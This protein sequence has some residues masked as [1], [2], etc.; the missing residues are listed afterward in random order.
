MRNVVGVRSSPAYAAV[1]AGLAAVLLVSAAGHPLTPARA[2]ACTDTDPI[3]LLYCQLGGSASVLGTPLGAPYTVGAG[4]GQDY[5]AGSIVWSSPT[6]AHEV[7]GVIAARYRQLRG[8]TGLMGFPTSDQRTAA[9]GVGTY[10]HFQGGSIF[11]SP[12][13][14][15][16]EVRGLLRDR[17]AALGW[18]RGLLGY[19]VGGTRAA[20]KDGAG[21]S[22]D[23]Q[24]GSI[25]W[26][27][28][29]GAWEVRGLLRD[30][31]RA[32]GSESG[33]LGYPTSGTRTAADTV[34]RYNHFQGGSIFWSPSTGAWEVRGVLRDRWAALGWER[35]VLGYPVTGSWATADTVGRYNRFQ[36]GS[37]FY[38]PSTGAHAVSGVI[39][40]RWAASGAERGPLGYPIT[41]EY[42]VNGGRQSDFQR[43]FLRLTSATGS[44]RQ[45]ILAPY[46]RAGT[47]VTR[48]RFSREF[49]GAAPPITPATVDAMAAAGVHTIYI[50]A[51]ADD[52]RFPGLLSP[53]LLAA[54]LTR[55]HARGLQVV[56][57]YLPHL[58]DVNADMR[59]LQAMIDFRASGQAFDAIGVDIEDLSVTD[60]DTRNARLVDLSAR[61]F[62]AAPN[63]T[64]S[65]I[66]LPPVVTDVLNTAYWPRFPWRQLAGYYQVWMPMAYWS[67]RT[68]LP[69]SD[70][71][72][73]TTENI[74][75]VRQN[76]GESCAA[77]SVIGGYGTAVSSAA[78]SAMATGARER[79]AIG[80]SIFDW[81]T[82]PSASWA[83]VRGYN[84]RGC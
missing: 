56:A 9:D 21:R 33:V 78:Y 77:V 14:G 15:A 64:L 22:N 70:A 83:A 40:A 74:N 66:V 42:A 63:V 16:W 51:A 25:Y 27:A 29:T 67:N 17:W 1:V 82:T 50:Q 37:I 44:I 53:D 31:W 48:Y 6:G 79:G 18:E 36:G 71:Y 19:P 4:R 55:A 8:P 43:G 58:T 11:W 26:S 81:T 60:V 13:T 45:A 23:F 59:R 39:G 28:A 41:D 75:R 5:T 10:N 30:R 68:T 65:A 49:A 72:R 24:G 7:H 76:L 34:G 54:F 47:W 3:A 62:A 73:Y 38:S 35:G 69:Y 12:S 80:V 20:G 57:W 46:Q 84:T 52:P 32:L 61:L 2:S